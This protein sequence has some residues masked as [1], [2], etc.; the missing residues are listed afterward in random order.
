MRKLKVH[1]IAL[2]SISFCLV[3]FGCSKPEGAAVEQA[4]KPLRDAPSKP[5]GSEVEQ[6]V[7][8]LRDALQTEKG[9]RQ[10]DAENLSPK[11]AVRFLVAAIQEKGELTKRNNEFARE[12]KEYAHA[13]EIV[14]ER[15]GR[16]LRES[17]AACADDGDLAVAFEAARTVRADYKQAQS[18]ERGL[19][20]AYE[21]RN[22]SLSETRTELYGQIDHVIQK[23]R[24]ALEVTV[25]SADQTLNNQQLWHAVK[26]AENSFVQGCKSSA[27][28]ELL[29]AIADYDLALERLKQAYENERAADEAA[30]AKER[31]LFKKEW[32]F[33][34][35]TEKVLEL[36]VDD[37]TQAQFQ[38]LRDAGRDLT[39]LQ[40]KQQQF[41]EYRYTTVRQAHGEAKRLYDAAFDEFARQLE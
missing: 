30:P 31:E 16:M 26:D 12:D 4:V 37:S 3:N 25:K 9:K 19:R 22:A 21:A 11:E 18:V 40:A 1:L 29:A 34:S 28:P 2:L 27:K 20:P 35:L 38:Q 39:K 14:K 7:E 6:A 23:A 41:D 10:A 15:E 32:E 8:Q 17:A 24:R 13:Q 33:R 5:D 36:P